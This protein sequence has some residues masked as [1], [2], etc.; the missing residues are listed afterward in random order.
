MDI[1][2]ECNEINENSKLE[3]ER[4]DECL[5]KLND[6]IRN[7]LIKGRILSIETAACEATVEWK[8][9]TEC[10]FTALTSKNVNFLRCF[11]IENEC[12]EA[13]ERIRIMDFIPD[14]ISG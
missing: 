14:H 13:G 8:I 1:V 6:L 5:A 10:S 3:F 11:Y 2:P 9:D 4:L 12:L 7:G